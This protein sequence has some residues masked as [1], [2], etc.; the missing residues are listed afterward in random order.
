MV[1]EMVVVVMMATLIILRNDKL[2]PAE[3][4]NVEKKCLDPQSFP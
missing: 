4:P 1:V 3:P 2:A